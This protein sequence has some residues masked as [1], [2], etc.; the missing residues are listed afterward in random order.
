MRLRVH[1][2]AGQ[3]RERIARA[4]GHDF[5]FNLLERAGVPEL[6][7]EVR[8][9]LAHGDVAGGLDQDQV[10]G[11]QRHQDQDDEQGLAH[12]VALR[13]EVQEAH[14]GRG[15]GGRRSGR[16]CG[17]GA[18]QRVGRLLEH[19]CGLLGGFADRRGGLR[20]RR[21]GRC[22][23]GRG[24]RRHGRAGSRLRHQGGAMQCVG[25]LSSS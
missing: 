1:G 15:D 11:H 5:V 4:V 3:V 17:G 13:D 23:G 25:H 20:S 16:Q 7:Q 14:I 24:G 12:E 10:P 18:V 8:R 9:A 22:G 6:V 2:M 21:R 19:A